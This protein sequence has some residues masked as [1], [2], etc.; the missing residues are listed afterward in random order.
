MVSSSVIEFTEIEY[1]PCSVT[2]VKGPAVKTPSF[3]IEKLDSAVCE[4]P[5]KLLAVNAHID[6]VYKVHVEGT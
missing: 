5:L 1:V 2:S 4:F 3:V 6:V